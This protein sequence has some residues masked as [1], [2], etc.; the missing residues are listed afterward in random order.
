M[1][2]APF[3]DTKKQK[4]AYE[5]HWRLGLVTGQEGEARMAQDVVR[6]LLSAG[7]NPAAQD[8]FGQTPYDVAAFLDCKEAASVLSPLVQE[9]KTKSSVADLWYLMKKTHSEQVIQGIDIDNVDPF[10]VLQA[11]ICQ[12]NEAVFEALLKAGVDPKLTGPNGLTSVHTIA[13]WDLVSMMKILA[14]YVKDLNVFSPLLL[15]VAA[16]RK[17]SNKQMF[18][19]LI[20]LGVNVNAIYQEID[21][22][23]LRTT[24]IPIPSY[25]A[26][27]ILAV[28]KHWWDIGAIESLCEAGADLEVLDGDGSTVLQ[29]ALNG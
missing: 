12:R 9:T 22:E 6:V 29:F 18:E 16:T 26:A 14:S 25:A 5:A 11:A 17:Q 7:A 3:M 15:Q 1:G 27:H 23:T 8:D 4:K 28:G 21:G 20:N 13:H 10:T 19:L 2:L 24:G